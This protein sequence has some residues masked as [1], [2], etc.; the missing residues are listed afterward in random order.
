MSMRDELN[1][2]ITSLPEN[3]NN[4]NNFTEKIQ[5]IK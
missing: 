2:V 4:I 1:G 3:N 5:V